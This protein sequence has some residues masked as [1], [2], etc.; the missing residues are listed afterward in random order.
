LWGAIAV[1]AAA[2][3]ILRALDVLPAGLFDLILRAWPAL[4]IVAGLG[5]L[6]RGRAP[7]SG[8]IALGVAVAITANIAAL[9][10]A[11]R[12]AQQRDD[13]RYPIAQ[14]IDPGISLLVLEVNGLATQIE[15]NIAD[16]GAS[17]I[18]GEFV[19]SSESVIAQAYND[20]GGGLASLRLTEAQPNAIQRLDA[21]GRGALRLALPAGLGL[22]LALTNESG[23]V[24]LNLDRA[25]L[26]RLNLDVGQGDAIVTLPTYAPQSPTFAQDPDAQTGAITVRGGALTLTVPEGVAA[27][28]ALNRGD[29]VFEPVFNEL[30]YN[31][32]RSDV[33]EAR[34]ID[35]ASL[36][37]RY[38]LNVPRGT[39]RVL[40]API[41]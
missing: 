28:L 4:L 7:L 25:A 1:A 11:A 37:V 31:Y 16:E 18:T 40:D 34:D 10:F 30:R 21:V 20:Q 17:A 41:P 23:T 13:Y 24:I 29:G 8:L 5:A 9:A 39:I 35:D 22:D 14:A 38:A 36:V 26:E 3:V 6:L 12:S 33:L 15:V 32:L 2:L 27:S 19:G